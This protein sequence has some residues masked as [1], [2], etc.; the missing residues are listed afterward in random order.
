MAQGDDSQ[1]Q[2]TVAD[3]IE[4][5]QKFDPGLPV[6]ITTSDEPERCYEKMLLSD[7]RRGEVRHPEI[8]TNGD[9]PAESEGIIIADD[10][11]FP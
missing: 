2:L 10:R 9:G 4:H 3:L 8:D 7:I 11:F 1:K 5:L 6:W